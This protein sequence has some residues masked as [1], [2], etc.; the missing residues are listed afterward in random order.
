MRR[1]PTAAKAGFRRPAAA[2]LGGQKPV[3]ERWT[4]GLEIRS[5][6]FT[7]GLFVTS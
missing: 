7:P 6:E 5:K 3:L 2:P 1:R 4:E